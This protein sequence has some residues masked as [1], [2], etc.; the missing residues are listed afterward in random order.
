[1]AQWLKVL[2]AL[3]EAPSSVPSTHIGK[4]ITAYN[5]SFG[6][7]EALWLPWACTHTWLTYILV[8]VHTCTHAYIKI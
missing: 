5:F 1:M 8:H 7:L 4:L 6:R 2:T 3:L